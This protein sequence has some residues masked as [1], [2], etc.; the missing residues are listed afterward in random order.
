M[1]TY[2]QENRPLRVLTPLGPDAL[3]LVGLSGYEAI[4][5]LFSFNLELLAENR[6]AIDFEKL[7]GNPVA[8]T[9]ELPNQTLRYFNGICSRVSQGVQE[10]DDQHFSTFTNF[11]ME[12]VPLLWLL[13][14][15]AQSRIF[16]HLSV[17]DIL[18][19]CLSGIPI[20]FELSGTFE[21]RDYCVQYRETDF[22]F[23]SRLMEEEGIYYFFKH[24]NNGQHQ[25]VVANTPQSHSDLTY[26]KS[27]IYESIAGGNRPDDRIFDWEKS[28][29]IR[30][31]KYTLWDHSFE[32]PH[33][34]L[35]VSEPIQESVA[36]GTVMHKLSAAKS[37]SLEIYDYPGGYAQR[38]DGITAGGSE[39]P[40]TLQKVFTDNSRTG[41]I[42]IQQEAVNGVT[43]IGSSNCR[44]FSSG[45]KFDLEHHFDGD[46]EYVLTSVSHTA[47]LRGYRS[48]GDAEFDYQNTFSC[49]PSALPFR[50]VRTTARPT[51]LGTQTA[52]VVGPSGEEIFTDKYGRVKVQFHWD[53]EGKT[54][55]N[56]S[57]WIRVAHNAAGKQ[58]GSFYIPRIGHEVVVAFEEGDPDRPIIVGAVYNATEMPPYELPKEKARSVV[59]KSNT[60]K[61]KGFNEI[62]IDDTKGKEQIFIHGQH[63]RDIRIIND[64]METIGN[65]SHLIIGKD[66]LELVKGDKHQIIKGDLN[67]K[68][69]GTVSLTVKED[70]LEKIDR[71]YALET[72]SEI[73]LKA[74]SNVVIEASAVL[75]LKVGGNFVTISGAGVAIKGMMV[76]INSGGA[77]ASGAAAQ[78]ETPKDAKEA[79]NAQAGSASKKAEAPPPLAPVTISPGA[80]V[81]QQAANSGAPLC[82]I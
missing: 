76:N 79:D 29:E 80:L 77:A 8:I 65:E 62:R 35:D 53:R 21:P 12:V 14:K 13:T 47:W 37:S 26:S 34:H 36:A 71:R 41:K 45:Y 68:V 18:K 7:L 73:H 51:V 55:E 81:M 6:E 50:P 42:R 27:I 30:S 75:T 69:E 20:S 33:K 67:E 59:F 4:S 64:Q 82:E 54:D 49:I 39:S 63:N 48:T 66:Q 3:L 23:V 43:I 78:P 17:P 52:L 44:H 60:Y 57:C 24:S 32:L 1:S 72:G 22:N 9:V 31:G 70:Q 46:G 19:K 15:R 5:Q 61:G 58:W 56:S 10:G 38:F 11:R 2:K 16:Q 28:Q 25:M 74:G 40:S